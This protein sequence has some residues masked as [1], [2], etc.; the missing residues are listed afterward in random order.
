MII[1]LLAL[2]LL[3]IFGYYFLSSDSDVATDV[4][5]PVNYSPVGT[6]VLEMVEKLKEVKIESSVFQS[7]VFTSL[8]DFSVSLLSEIQGRDNPFDAI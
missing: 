3:A 8:K 5:I 1:G 4:V 2:L 7:S 6:D